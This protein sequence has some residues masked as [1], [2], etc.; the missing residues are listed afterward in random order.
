MTPGPSHRRRAILLLL[1]SIPIRAMAQS[2]TPWAGTSLGV[3]IGDLS[4]NACSAWTPNG[5]TTDPA[6]K[7][8]CATG[9]HF[10]GGVQLGEN[11][12]YKHLTWGLSADLDAAAST[13]PTQ[14]VKQTGGAAPPGTYLFPGPQTPKAFAI[15]APRLGYA[16]DLWLPYLRAGAIIA[17]GAHD[18]TL[19]FTPVGATKPI[20]SFDGARNSPSVGWVAGGGTDIGLN[21]PWSITLEYLHARLGK[22]SDGTAACSGTAAACSAFSGISFVND[23]GP[24]IANLYRVGITYWFG[25]W[26]R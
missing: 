3:G 24:L 10:M 6:A 4:S 15:V 21:G 8:T 23:R 19:T 25:Y 18:S 12:Q 22:G 20:A 9:G 5:A 2:E 7:Q 16:G 11:F 26:G 13:T 17:S 14:S 1:L